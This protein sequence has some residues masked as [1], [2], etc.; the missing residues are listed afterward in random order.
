MSN[1]NVKEI[2]VEL[3]INGQPIHVHADKLHESWLIWALGYGLHRGPNDKHSGLKGNEKFDAV[4]KFVDL[5]ESGDAMPE[6]VY[7]SRTPKDPIEA[8]A[9]KD[10][11]QYLLGAWKAKLEVNAIK[12]IVAADENAAK[13]FTDDNVWIDDK[14]TA[15]IEKNVKVYDFMKEAAE[16]LSSMNALKI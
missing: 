7:V 2:V 6:R 11:K 4:R 9:M 10:A 1:F 15:F 13:F 14:V 12:D 5:M 16:S 8:R 3:K